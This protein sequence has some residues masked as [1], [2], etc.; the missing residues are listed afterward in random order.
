MSK[1]KINPDASSKLAKLVAQKSQSEET[2][3]HGFIAVDKRKFTSKTYRFNSIDM[4][5]LTKLVANVNRASPY[6]IYNES[7]VIRGL[8]FYSATKMDIAKF[9][10]ALN[11][12]L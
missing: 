1:S 7:D 11:N 2:E 4:D 3:N 8:I 12:R 5:M 9:L 6:K 10:K